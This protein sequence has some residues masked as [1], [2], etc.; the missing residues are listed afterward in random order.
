MH[1]AAPSPVP[2]VFFTRSQ[3][4][5][6]R[7]GPSPPSPLLLKLT[8]FGGLSLSRDGQPMT[9]AAAQRSRLALLALL[10]SAGPAGISRDKLLL[11]LWPESDSERARHA[12]KQAVY[13][14]R[15]DLG[16]EE[17]IQGTASLSLNASLIESDIREFEAALARGDRGAA[18]ALYTGAFLDGVYLKE[19]PEFERWCAEM[20]TRLSQ[21]WAKAVEGLARECESKGEW[22]DAVGRWRQLAA[23]EPLSG[24]NT[25]LLMRALAESG[26]TSAALAQYRVHE[27]LMQQEM[28]SPPDPEVTKLADDMRQGRWQRS[29]PVVMTAPT[30]APAVA[31]ATPTPSPAAS[32]PVVT[33]PRELAP[34]AAPPRRSYAL[35][36]AAALVFVIAAIVAVS[37]GLRSKVGLV[38]TPDLSNT[39]LVAP[40]ANE[41]GDSAWNSLATGTAEWIGR[42]LDESGVVRVVAS[43]D[44]R[45]VALAVASVE[46]GKRAAAMA[47]QTGVDTLIM[48]TI[49]LR[50]DSLEIV[51]SVVDARTGLEIKAIPAVRALARRDA[52]SS[53]IDRAANAASVAVYGMMKKSPAA[54]T[55]ALTRPPNLDAFD[56]I[57]EAYVRFFNDVSDTG[58]VFAMF[59][60]AAKLAPDFAGAYVLKAYIRDVKGNWPG[61]AEMMPTLRRLRPSMTRQERKALDMFEADLAGDPYARL[62]AARELSELSPGSPEMPILAAVSELYV[63]RVDSAVVAFSHTDGTKGINLG[64]PVYWGWLSVTQH[65]ANDTIGERTSVESGMRRFSR[66]RLLRHPALAAAARRGDTTAIDSLLAPPIRDDGDITLARRELMLLAGRELRAHG[67]ADLGTRYTKRALEDARANPVASPRSRMQEATAL[68]EATMYKEARERFRAL[69]QSEKSEQDRVDILGRLGAIAMRL[70]DSTE[71]RRIDSQLAAMTGSFLLGRHLKWRAHIAALQGRTSDAVNLL[72]SATKAGFRLMDTAVIDIHHD[73]DFLTLTQTREYAEFLRMMASTNR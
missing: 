9:G 68:Y 13:A 18:V 62:R 7:C 3:R 26:D 55:T 24:R 56:A 45:I 2:Y 48:G 41:T 70:G 60:S 50:G 58:R 51:S 29:A 59:D 40:F 52:T 19:A 8:T 10:A 20:R 28:E 21:D 23:A 54:S 63:G 47:A 42:G 34:A 67:H 15:R 61:L 35:G 31:P 30:V 36:I 72:E 12:L 53:L 11:F 6:P 25:M 44:A 57:E 37:P 65:F 1:L 22:R 64:S 46:Q 73:S 5:H 43:T 27:S 17:T 49:Y 69:Q 39:I 71:A 14:L 38:S 32:V 33:P 16:D 66:S 4:P